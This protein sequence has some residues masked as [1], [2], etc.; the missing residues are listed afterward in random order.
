[1]EEDV[2][3]QFLTDEE[4]KVDDDLGQESRDEVVKRISHTESK[5]LNGIALCSKGM[6]KNFFL[7]KKFHDQKNNEGVN[8]QQNKKKIVNL[9]DIFERETGIQMQN[10]N[11]DD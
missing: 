4:P 3:D 10:E 2:I 1:M 9:S 6:D 7:L 8:Y 5:I 11:A